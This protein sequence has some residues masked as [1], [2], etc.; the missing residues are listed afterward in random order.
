[1]SIV[2]QAVVTQWAPDGLWEIAA[3]LIPPAPRRRQGGGRRRGDDRAI[4]AAILYMT[5][6]GCSW[7]ALPVVMFG[8]SRTTTHRRFTE[9]TAAGLWTRLHY[10]ATSPPSGPP[11]AGLPAWR[12][13]CRPGAGGPSAAG[14]RRRRRL[15][16]A[17]RPVAAG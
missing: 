9:W 11:A 14:R 12:H 10:F 5:E 15:R 16:P 7:P 3:P 8:V 1:M 13:R 6:A 2:E 17:A 4:L